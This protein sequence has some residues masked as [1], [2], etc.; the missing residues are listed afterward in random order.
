MDIVSQ[1]GS[2]SPNADNAITALCWHPDS[3]QLAVNVSPA[4]L[5]IYRL[6][7]AGISPVLTFALN[8]DDGPVKELHWQTNVR[9]LTV[10]SAA[11]VH[12]GLLVSYWE[13][14]TQHLRGSRHIPPFSAWDQDFK[15]EVRVDDRLLY[16]PTKTAPL[17]QTAQHL[18]LSPNGKTA[19]I[20]LGDSTPPRETFV[21]YAPGEI[22]CNMSALEHFPS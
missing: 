21:R 12:A 22:H 10:I 20:I 5:S 2:P 7:N 14:S 13:P 9:T 1:F 17:S 15:V 3:Q 8:P 18:Q 6:T 16:L 4:T 11:N 19:V